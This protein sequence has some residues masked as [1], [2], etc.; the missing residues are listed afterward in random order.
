MLK[1]NDDDA[2]LVSAPILAI[3]MF[4]VKLFAIDL[5]A[6]KILVETV[7]EENDWNAILA[8]PEIREAREVKFNDCCIVLKSVR[9]LDDAIFA[10]K[11]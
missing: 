5:A 10:E 2:A 11:I 7:F 9:S 1:L 8:I 3:R 6:E 4:D